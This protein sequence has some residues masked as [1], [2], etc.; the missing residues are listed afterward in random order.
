MVQRIYY[1]IPER[2]DGYGKKKDIIFNLTDNPSCL[3]ITVDNGT[4]FIED[5]VR[6]LVKDGY[7]VVVTDQ[8]PP[9]ELPT[10]EHQD[11]IICNPRYMYQKIILSTLSLGV[12]FLLS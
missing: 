10:Y 2:S 9:I 4:D 7:I 3:V 6:Q 12:T 8:H 11:P 1:Y 5:Q